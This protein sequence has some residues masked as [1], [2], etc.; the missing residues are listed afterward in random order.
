[1]VGKRG[2]EEREE[3]STANRRWQPS[4]L[5]KQALQDIF[6]SSGILITKNSSRAEHYA[7]IYFPA[8]FI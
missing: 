2:Q 3:H 5:L 1:M 4:Y 7:M 6:L 8:L